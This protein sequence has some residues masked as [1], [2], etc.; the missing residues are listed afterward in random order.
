MKMRLDNMSKIA[1]VR[2]MEDHDCSRCKLYETVCRSNASKFCGE[3]KA[4][5]LRELVPDKDQDFSVL[6]GQMARC[7]FSINSLAREVPMQPN[8]LTLRLI[9]RS[10]FKLSEMRRIADILG[11]TMDILFG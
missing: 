7:G 10:D 3:V 6:R 5:Y 1:V 9:G 2:F 11:C 4:E 8:T